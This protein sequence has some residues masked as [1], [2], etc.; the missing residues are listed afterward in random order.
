MT[1]LMKRLAMILTVAVGLALA[2]P[3]V[4]LHAQDDVQK[5][6]VLVND[7]PI[8][9]YDIAQR[10]RLTSVTTR[11]QP[12]AAMRKKAVEELISEN[13]QI[14]EAR[15]F[16]VRA[17]RK[18]VDAALE[19]IGRRNNMTGPKLLAA[20]GQLGVGPRTMRQKIEASIVW[21]RVVQGK[22]RH[23]V[24]IGHAQIDKVLSENAAE[25][26]KETTV[27]QLR[28]CAPRIAREPQ[29]EGHCAALGGG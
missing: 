20:L 4:T 14:Q 1:M 9:D 21:Q 25:E 24:N 15:K 7:T 3:M 29:S 2:M 13:I 28:R 6:V 8:T 23:Q 17:S 19:T 27:F 5:I 16:G 11:Q 18:E 22:F 26:G 12:T 10:V